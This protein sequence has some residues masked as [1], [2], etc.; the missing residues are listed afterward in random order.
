MRKGHCRFLVL[1]LEN[2]AYSAKEEL[3]MSCSDE[4]KTS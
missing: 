4:M 2:L 3:I 1:I